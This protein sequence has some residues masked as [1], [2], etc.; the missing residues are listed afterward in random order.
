MPYVRKYAVVVALLF[1]VFVANAIAQA[2]FPQPFTADMTMKNKSGQDMT[3]KYYVGTNKMRFD[4]N[5]HGQNMSSIID[6]ATKTSYML[7]HQQKMYME[8]HA[9]Q[10]AMMQR[11]PKMPDLKS[12]DPSNPCANDPDVT[13]KNEG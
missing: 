10:N 2:Q 7:M 8:I 9:G 5:A 6:P 13:C 12:Y 3:G 11:G 4:M 1:G